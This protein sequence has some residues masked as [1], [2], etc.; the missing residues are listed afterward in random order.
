MIFFG[1]P[2]ASA[3]PRR[4]IQHVFGQLTRV[5]GFV[6]NAQIDNTVLPSK[7]QLE[8][9]HNVFSRFAREKGWTIYSFQEQYGDKVLNSEKVREST[10]PSENTDFYRSLKIQLLV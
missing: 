8:E 9:L 10:V 5:E 4:L 2:H 3:D 1:T 7:E 6:V